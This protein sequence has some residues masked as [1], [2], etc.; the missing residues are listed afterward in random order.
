MYLAMK[1]LL[2]FDEKRLRETLWQVLAKRLVFM[3][4]LSMIKAI[5]KQKK[6]YVAGKS[7]F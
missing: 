6:V 7:N 1:N 5:K 3:M 4:M 2:E